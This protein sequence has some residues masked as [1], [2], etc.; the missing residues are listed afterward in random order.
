MLIV[1]T[2]NQ[3]L[4][5][6]LEEM[7]EKYL[8][9]VDEYPDD[10]SMYIPVGSTQFLNRFNGEC[11]NIWLIDNSIEGMI[12]RFSKR[13]LYCNSIIEVIPPRNYI[14]YKIPEQLP[15]EE[16]LWVCLRNKVLA[17]FTFLIINNRPV[18]E[19]EE[20]YHSRLVLEVKHCAKLCPP[21]IFVIEMVV[22]KQNGGL[23]HRVRFI[24]SINKTLIWKKEYIGALN[25]FFQAKNR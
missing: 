2:P 18:I 9:D 19:N 17:R 21:G 6:L 12:D 13:Y 14:D 7:N 1:Q 23:F 11:D 16:L 24:E 25:D 20:E 8:T 5:N 10:L 22:A 4:I 15:D 3:K